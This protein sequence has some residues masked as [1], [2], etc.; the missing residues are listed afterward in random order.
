MARLENQEFAELVEKHKDEMYYLALS[1]LKN[2]VDA[3]DAVSETVVRAYE[4]RSRLRKLEKFKP[5]IMQILVNVSKTLLRKREKIVLTEDAETINQV[6][7]APKYDMWGWVMELEYE[8]RTVIILYY[9]EGF[10][11]KEIA[12]I[13]NIPEG[14]VRSRL[15]RARNK[16][17][18]FMEAKSEKC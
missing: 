11:T 4:A 18:I 15:A 7:S 13:L 12:K 14:T 8:F 2:E 5:W 10:S 16:L 3:Q 9:Y 17:K 6:E 1:I